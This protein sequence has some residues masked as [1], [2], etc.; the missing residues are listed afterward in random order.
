M[1]SFFE[2]PWT[3]F[4]IAVAVLYAIFRLRSIFP[5]KRRW[6]QWLI[7]VLIAVS[8]FGLDW[9]IQTDFEKINTLIYTGIK[10]VEEEETSAIEAI[11]SADYQDSR[12]SSKEHLIAHG[13][14]ELSQSLVEESKK[15]S[16]QLEISPPTATVDLIVIVKFEEDSYV[17]QN[18][19]QSL[20]VEAKLYLQKE[21]DKKW[22]INRVEILKIDNQPVNWRQI[23]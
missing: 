12:H 4:I 6:W 19:K 23:R 9:I 18:Y 11:V 10:A 1:F 3:L 15:L 2:Q 5:K 13:R 8:A 21:P 16:L 7:P 14:R 17:A 20:I 22:L